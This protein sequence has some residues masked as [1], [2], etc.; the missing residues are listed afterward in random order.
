ML[1]GEH[2]IFES[3]EGALAFTRSR[4]GE[5]LR[6][7]LFVGDEIALSVSDLAS[8]VAASAPE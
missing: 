8:A 2:S 1:A 6:G 4:E 5:A 3:V 7:R